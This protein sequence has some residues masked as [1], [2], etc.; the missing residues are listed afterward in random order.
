M[1]EIIS[2][3]CAYENPLKTNGPPPV[4]G[5]QPRSWNL[6]RVGPK[7]LSC[8][9]VLQILNTI[10]SISYGDLLSLSPRVC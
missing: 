10:L 4:R 2:R 6:P 8:Q 3:P 7:R 1:I 9:G 5:N